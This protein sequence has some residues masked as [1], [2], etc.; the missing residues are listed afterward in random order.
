[1]TALGHQNLPGFLRRGCCNWRQICTNFSINIIGGAAL[2]R[3]SVKNRF[4]LL[5]CTKGKF[6]PSRL[7]NVSVTFCYSNAT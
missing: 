4:P 1:M 5:M 2:A 7:L 6:R 3:K